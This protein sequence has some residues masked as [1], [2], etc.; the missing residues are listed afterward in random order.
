MNHLSFNI[1]LFSGAKQERQNFYLRKQITTENEQKFV[2]TYVLLLAL[3]E[4]IGPINL[5]IQFR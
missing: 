1:E 5:I 4:I 2:Y 3:S